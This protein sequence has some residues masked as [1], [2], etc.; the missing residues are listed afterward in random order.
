MSTATLGYFP[1]LILTTR[2]VQRTARLPNVSLSLFTV[3]DAFGSLRIVL[4]KC[5][6]NSAQSVV[7]FGCDL[8]SGITAA[9]VVAWARR[10]GDLCNTLAS[11]GASVS[12]RLQKSSS[13]S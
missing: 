7:H 5:F 1:N 2:P 9:R 10:F 13:D 12:M 3:D 4:A 11:N 6:T 8:K